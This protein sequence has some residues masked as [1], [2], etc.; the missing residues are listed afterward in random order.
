[1][2]HVDGLN[3]IN[4]S[5]C[6]LNN[7]LTMPSNLDFVSI[8]CKHL[9]GIIHVRSKFAV[10]VTRDIIICCTDRQNQLINDKGSVTNGPADVRGR[11]IADVNT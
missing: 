10:I 9:P 6:K 7:A 1:M 4:F 11:S 8:A 2:D 5:K 3:M